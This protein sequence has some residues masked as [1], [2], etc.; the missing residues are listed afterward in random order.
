MAIKKKLASVATRFDQPQLDR[1]QSSSIA[2]PSD[3][4][5]MKEIS[6][7]LRNKEASLGATSTVNIYGRYSIFDPCSTGDIFGMQVETH[8]LIN[9]IGWR[10]NRFYRRRVDFITWMA[11]KGTVAGTATTGAGAPCDDPAGGFEFGK[12][13]YELTHSSWYHRADDPLD[14][15][16]IIQDRC[17]TTPRYRLDGKIITDDLEWQMNGLMTAMTQSL[18]RDLVHGS[19]S[20]PYEMDGFESIIKTGYTDDDG[21]ATPMLDSSIISWNDDVDGLN[22]GFGNFFN[23]LDEVV[24]EL[25]YRAQNRG[26]IAENDMILL[27]SRFNAT[28]LLDSYA[29]YTTCGVTDSND[30][31]E[32]AMRAQ[33][34]AAR[35]SLNGGPL[36]DG[37]QAVGFLQL[38][39]GR[40]LPIMV[41]DS[42]DISKSGTGLWASDAY[43]LTRRI[44]NQDVL[45][46]EYLDLREYTNRVKKQFSAFSVQSDAAGR[47]ALKGKE[48]NWCVSMMMGTSPEIYLAAPWAQVRFTG[49]T[50]RRNRQP[51]V[52]DPFQKA[53]L[54]GG[55]PTTTAN[56]FGAP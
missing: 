40:R 10:P 28:N 36:Y 32:Q 38:K 52:G 48:D 20:N 22:N 51:L 45:Y 44:G 56:Y 16:T 42:L 50:A 19:H 37:N 43:L 11:P 54:P 46:G 17:E 53:Y 5:V 26:G 47:F 2:T 39:S 7:M 34:R 12:G 1:R 23:Y 3:A 49:L 35:L 15:H 14:P 9:W 31:T 13:G 21:N 8:G 29:C 55:A 33:Q 41:E 6:N 4:R 30:I 25:E 18:R 27:T 24:T